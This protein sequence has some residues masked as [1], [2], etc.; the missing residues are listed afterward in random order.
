MIH[1]YLINCA[2][3]N[4]VRTAVARGSDEGGAA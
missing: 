1:G 4:Q 2:S 3:G